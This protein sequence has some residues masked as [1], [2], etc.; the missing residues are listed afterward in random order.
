MLFSAKRDHLRRVLDQH[1]RRAATARRD[2]EAGRTGARAEIGEPAG[3]AGRHRGGQHHRVHAGA[4][5]GTL[6]LHQPEIAAVEGVDRRAGRFAA[7]RH[8]VARAQPFLIS[9]PMPASARM[10]RALLDL[11]GVDHDAARQDAE[12]AVEH[13]HVLVGDEIAD[14]GIAHQRLDEG[15]DDGVVGADQFFHG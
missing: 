2:G 11:V 3:K 6:R 15:D 1:D 8:R 13:A 9:L 10:V 5:A 7:G 12:R 14:A 4:M